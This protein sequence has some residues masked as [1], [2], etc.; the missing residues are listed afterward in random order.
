[1]I[2]IAGDI[3]YSFVVTCKRTALSIHQLSGLFLRIELPVDKRPQS[4]GEMAATNGFNK[5]PAPVLPAMG[6]Y[7]FHN[8]S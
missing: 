5:R 7:S 1:M 3:L 6:L 2:N 8:D 4:S